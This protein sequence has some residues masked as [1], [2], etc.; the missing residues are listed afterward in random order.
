MENL[1]SSARLFGGNTPGNISTKLTMAAF[2]SIALYNA[3][4]LFVLILL[5]FHRYTGVYFWSILLSNTMGVIPATIGSLLDFYDIGPLWLILTVSNVGFWFLVPGQ[6]VVLYSRLHI[7]SQNYKALKWLRNIIIV[8]S[9]ALIIPTTVLYYGAA[10]F[11]THPWNQAFTIIERIQITW[12]CAQEI[13]ISTF[14][15]WETVKLIRFHHD[16]QRSRLLYELIAINL[17]AILMDVTLLALE[18]LDFYFIQVII[19]SSVYSI[20]LKMEFAVLGRL[21]A[22]VHFRRAEP[23]CH[24][25]SGTSSSVM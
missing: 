9:I 13:L 10:Y 12:F 14:Y 22:I 17:V 8:D 4:E 1:H 11:K 21:I 20:K 2:I 16:R 5:T 19:K 25:V 15:I 18:Y 6:S 24:D 3:V 7:I 23:V